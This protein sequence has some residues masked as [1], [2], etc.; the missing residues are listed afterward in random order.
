MYRHSSGVSLVSPSP[1]PSTKRRTSRLGTSIIKSVFVGSRGGR[2]SGKP[3]ASDPSTQNITSGV[4][5]NCCQKKNCVKVVLFCVV[6]DE[7]QHQTAPNAWEAAAK[8]QSS[9]AAQLNATEVSTLRGQHD[10]NA[11]NN[12]FNILGDGCKGRHVKMVFTRIF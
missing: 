8:A 1:E 4:T 5:S 10:V 6:L 9:L 12:Y 11:T 3:Q 7:K 2:S